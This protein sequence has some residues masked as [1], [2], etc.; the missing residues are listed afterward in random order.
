MRVAQI[1]FAVILIVSVHSGTGSS[2]ERPLGQPLNGLKVELKV[3]KGEVPSAADLRL[4]ITLTNVS[5]KDL[6][7]DPWPGHFFVQLLD[8]KYNGIPAVRAADV[9]RPP[10]KPKRLEPG[11]EHTLDSEGLSLTTGLEGST[12]NWSYQELPTGIYHLMAEYV[13]HKDPAHPELWTGGINTV[14]AKIELCGRKC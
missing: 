4:V 1:A 5:K 14:L 13:V 10:T 2:E 9:L 11:E 3:R 8:H 6:M 7:I 12:Q